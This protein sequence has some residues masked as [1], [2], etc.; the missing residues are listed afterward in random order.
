MPALAPS[1]APT[2]TLPP[3]TLPEVVVRLQPDLATIDVVVADRVVA[4]AAALIDR[5]PDRRRSGTLQHLR[6]EGRSRAGI[7]NGRLRAIRSRP[8]EPAMPPGGADWN[9]RREE[10]IEMHR[11]AR[12]LPVFTLFLGGCSTL[13]GPPAIMRAT[14]PV[15]A[16]HGD[17]KGLIARF[18][19]LAKT[20]AS[21]SS[22]DGS[23]G[24]DAKAMLED[25]FTLVYAHCNDFFLH[26]GRGQSQL[27][28]LKDVTGALVG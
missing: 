16:K 22:G 3:S 24:A 9:F 20:S 1:A 10:S 23:E 19:A 4:P 12:S 14:G 15:V 6:H 21:A 26:A 18:A 27:L 13:N 8:C 5:V 25:G 2:P 11:L 7:S 17:D 28:V